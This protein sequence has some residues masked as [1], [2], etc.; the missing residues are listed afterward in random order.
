[1]AR[2]KTLTRVSGSSRPH[3]TAVDA[4]WSVV[5]ADGAARYFQLSTFGSEDRASAPKVSQTIQLDRNSALELRIALEE[6]F[7]EDFL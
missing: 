4:E 3:P 7:P 5:I 6:T 1:M 2:I